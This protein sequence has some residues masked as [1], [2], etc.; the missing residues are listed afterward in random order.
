MRLIDSKVYICIAFGKRGKPK[1]PL[2]RL[3]FGSMDC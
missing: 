2:M 3:M 1:A